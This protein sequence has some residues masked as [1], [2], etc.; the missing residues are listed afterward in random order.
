MPTFRPDQ[1]TGPTDTP[2]PEDLASR[3]TTTA[4]DGLLTAEEVWNEIG[5][6]V[7]SDPT[8]EQFT[9]MDSIR[10]TI[11][12]VLRGYEDRAIAEIEQSGDLRRFSRL[13][14]Q[15][16]LTVRP[17]SGGLRAVGRA[18]VPKSHLPYFFS[19]VVAEDGVP[20][21]PTDDATRA[22]HAS[23]SLWDDY[24]YERAGRDVI[25]VP[26]DLSS[27]DVWLVPTSEAVEAA[28]RGLVPEINQEILDASRQA[29]ERRAE[30]AGQ[31]K[32][33]SRGDSL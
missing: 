30:G 9:P 33:E 31:I 12:R 11:T 17:Q 3:A 21:A 5:W 6:P 4:P 8:S 13:S 24:R 25:V 7:H 29:L 1:Q 20:L 27:I 32:A 14:D 22:A 18:R 10:A 19:K 2:D 28:L 16:T 26:S 23:V 15:H